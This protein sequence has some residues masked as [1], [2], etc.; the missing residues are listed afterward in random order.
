[1]S[2]SHIK[3]QTSYLFLFCA[4]VVPNNRQLSEMYAIKPPMFFMFFIRQEII[5]PPYPHQILS[6][7]THSYMQIR[8]LSRYQQF[9]IVD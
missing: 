4:T 3:K 5:L 7:Y 9:Q 8:P 6:K 2:T 1:M